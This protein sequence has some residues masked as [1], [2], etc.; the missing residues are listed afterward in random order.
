MD[1]NKSYLKI[2]MIAPK[3]VVKS[4]ST[5]MIQG[6]FT[7]QPLI[8]IGFVIYLTFFATLTAAFI[9]PLLTT[10]TNFQI[11]IPL[12]I[13]VLIPSGFYMLVLITADNRARKIEE[14]LPDALEIISA[15]IRAG[16]TLENAIWLSARP[17][18]GPLR[19]EIKKLSADTFGGKPIEENL[20]AMSK[21]VRSEIIERSMQLIQEGIMLGGEMSNLLEE[22]AQDTRNTQ[23]LKKQISTSTI[24]YTLFI[25]FAATIM[26]PLLFSISTTYS[27][28]SQNLLTTSRAGSTGILL[29]NIPFL[30]TQGQVSISPNDIF[31]F[32]LESIIIT[33]FLAA[34]IIG[35]IRF[36]KAT[37]G[38]GYVPILLVVSVTIFLV[39]QQLL[40]S[41]IQGFI[42]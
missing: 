25:V 6:G 28:I 10:N 11:I 13:L 24:T 26:A 2:S 18:F 5:L 9:S 32:A 37:R 29:Q 23:T 12:L 38:I 42:K 8:F 17:E 14:L 36:G 27:H 40:T 21:R 19:D 22:V 15:N 33:N 31:Y 20:E 1:F 39:T 35:Q 41:V 7:L 30:N 34:F 16:M 3:R 4:I